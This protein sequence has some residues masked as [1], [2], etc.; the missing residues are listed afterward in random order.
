MSIA[1]M[2][3]GSA[4]HAAQGKATKTLQVRTSGTGTVAS[5]DGRIDCGPDCSASYQRSREIE[6]TAA[7]GKDHKF[8]YWT[9]ACIGTTRQCIVV[10]GGG[11]K[12]VRAVFERIPRTISLMVSGPGTVTSEPPGLVCGSTGTKCTATFGQGSSIQLLASADAGAT[13]DAWDGLACAGRGTEC[14]VLADPDALVGTAA[15]FRSAAP[16]VGDVPLTVTPLVGAFTSSPAA[17]DCP[18]TCTASFPSGTE[19]RLSAGGISVRWQGGCQ[20]LSAECRLILDRAVEVSGSVQFP[21]TNTGK[22]AVNVS[23]TGPGSVSGGRSFTSRE[24]S[25]GGPT[26]SVLTCKRLYGPGTN[27][28]LRATPNRGARFDHWSY[29]CSGTNPQCTLRLSSP[30]T[31]IAVFRRR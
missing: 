20:G 26:S 27:V 14:D 11:P 29:F 16:A 10:V 8:A 31:V 6:L 23:V 17:I 4:A 1:L 9:G 28:R 30:K 12:R 24:I 15:V 19:V 5:A 13:F 7:G 25:C 22:F 21:A 2:I 18:P 3:S